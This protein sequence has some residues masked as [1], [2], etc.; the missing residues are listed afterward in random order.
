MAYESESIEALNNKGYTRVVEAWCDEDY[1][2]S[3]GVL[4]YS[5]EKNRYAMVT[6]V[7]GTCGGCNAWADESDEKIVKMLEDDIEILLTDDEEEA[8]RLF[9]SKK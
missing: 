3:G 2:G 9:A 8:K 5:G 6:Y 4:A 7:F 1:Q